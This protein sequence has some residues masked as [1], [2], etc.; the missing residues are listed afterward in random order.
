[1]VS[2]LYDDVPLSLTAALLLSATMLATLRDVGVLEF[3]L[4]E[5]K[6]LIPRTVLKKSPGAASFHFGFEMG[7]GFRTYITASSP[8]VLALAILVA[9][10]TI[11]VTLVGAVGFGV[12]RAFPIA[13]AAREVRRPRLQGTR[14]SRGLV[15]GSCGVAVLLGIL[16]L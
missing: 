14:I 2:T 13:A 6:R 10:P 7:T 1:V 9:Q 5:N 15:T 11:G 3:N 8:Y 12:G 4:P 16:A